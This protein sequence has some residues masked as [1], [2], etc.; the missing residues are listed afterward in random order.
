MKTEKFSYSI[1]K[2]IGNSLL[3]SEEQ[4]QVLAYGLFGMFQTILSI[5]IVIFLGYLMNI[6]VE[7]ILVSFSTAI[8][9]KFSG[10]AH[11]TS[12]ER[13]L[14]LGTFFSLLVALIG[15]LLIHIFTPSII[16]LII[17]LLFIW[18]F[19]VVYK[20]APVASPN[21]PINN[22]FKKQKLKHRSILV[23][24]IYLVIIITLLAL[25]TYIKVPFILLYSL[26]LI[27]G[28]S[29]QVFTL[30]KLGDKVVYT[31]DQVLIFILN[32][33]IKEKKT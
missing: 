20:K 18:T 33:F 1:A 25:Y 16:Y 17:G 13:C 8:L 6:M 28:I 3:Y 12:A 31:L 22:T 32:I 9:R 21:K 7:S 15:D 10:G 26:C 24:S 23:I 19:Y 2:Y 4:I 30:T 29:W 27:L 14:V 11:A 5:L